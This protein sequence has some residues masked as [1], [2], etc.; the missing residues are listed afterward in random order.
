RREIAEKLHEN[1]VLD[2]FNEVDVEAGLSRFLPVDILTSTGQRHEHDGLCPGEFPDPTCG[3]V[4]IEFRQADIQDDD[5]GPESL[6]SFDGLKT[7]VCRAGF[8]PLHSK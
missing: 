2:R 6:G 7:I 1:I 4:A 3:A 8:V 5:V